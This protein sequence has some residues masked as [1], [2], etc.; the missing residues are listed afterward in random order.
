MSIKDILPFIPQRPPFVMVDELVSVEDASGV[1][2]FAVKADNIFIQDGYL[3]APALVENI[4]QTAAARIGYICNKKNEPVP[5]GFIGAV[6][7]LEIKELPAVGDQIETEIIIKNQ[8]FDVTLISGK[9]TGK[10]REL[11]VCDMKIFLQANK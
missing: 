9:I 5:V 3:T 8:V 4:A 6:Q 2:R 1:T 11:A 10:G 7:N